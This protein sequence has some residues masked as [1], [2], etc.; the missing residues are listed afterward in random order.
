VEDVP[1]DGRERGLLVNGIFIVVFIRYR[2]D[3][4][5]AVVFLFVSIPD[6]G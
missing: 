3:S 2:G 6:D 1:L 4:R 5:Q